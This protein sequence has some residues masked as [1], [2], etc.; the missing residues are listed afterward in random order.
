[1]KNFIGG[2]ILSLQPFFRQPN[3]CCDIWCLE[4]LYNPDKDEADIEDE[5]LDESCP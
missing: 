2:N 5:Q 1:M 3:I 4:C